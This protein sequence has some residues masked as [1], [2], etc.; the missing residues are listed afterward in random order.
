[1]QGETMVSETVLGALF[2]FFLPLA[3]A[4]R[5]WHWYTFFKRRQKIKMIQATQNELND[6]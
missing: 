3:V 1:M 2:C 6:D 4:A 5:F